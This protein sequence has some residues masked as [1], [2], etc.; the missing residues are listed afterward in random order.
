MVTF[1]LALLLQQSGP[2]PGALD[3][4]KEQASILAD[5][6]AKAG[7]ALSYKA[8]YSM[9]DSDSAKDSSVGSDGTITL[10]IT[11]ADAKK[12]TAGTWQIAL[13][14][15]GQ[16]GQ[17]TTKFIASH[18]PKRYLTLWTSSKEGEEIDPTKDKKLRYWTYLAT[19]FGELL[20]E[21]D[22]KLV[23]LSTKYALGKTQKSS[24]GGETN[25]EDETKRNAKPSFDGY[26]C[27]VFL[28]TPKNGAAAAQCKRI[29]VAVDLELFLVMR[30]EFDWKGDGSTK[31]AFGL[32][33]VDVDAKIDDAVFNP[34]TKEYKIK[35]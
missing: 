29:V 4:A 24:Q 26:R 34:D 10:K 5:A 17:E 12:K 33:E 23:T 25:K 22:A 6:K 1:V 3:P 9:V 18:N 20:K 8:I 16:M 35:K 14:D 11:Q 27:H 7:K 30:V 21:H 19:P 28:L 32:K 13:E 2:D 31:S 15:N